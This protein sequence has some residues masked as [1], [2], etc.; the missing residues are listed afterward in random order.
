[1][2]LNAGSNKENEKAD[3]SESVDLS[4]NEETAEYWN[5][6]YEEE[7]QLEEEESQLEEEESLGETTTAES[8]SESLGGNYYFF[9]HKYLLLVI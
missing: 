3:G 4:W 1:L 7:S 5:Q 6:I 8:S 9:I 2:L